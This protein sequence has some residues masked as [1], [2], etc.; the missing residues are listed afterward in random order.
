MTIKSAIQKAYLDNN[1]AEIHYTEI[2]KVIHYK[3]YSSLSG[4][5]PQNTV[6]AAITSSIKD[7]E[8]IFERTGDGI[9]KMTYTAYER[10]K[11]E[12]L[13]EKNKKIRIATV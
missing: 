6:N 2:N 8:L 10:L 5:T 13:D 9:Y 7:N 12:K 1:N 11:K 4:V 3:G